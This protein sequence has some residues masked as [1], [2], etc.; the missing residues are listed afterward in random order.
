M[1]IV[2]KIV[3]KSVDFNLRIG[4]LTGR[5]HDRSEDIKDSITAVSKISIIMN[6]K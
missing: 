1:N 2:E 6:R 3:L 5:D 4:I